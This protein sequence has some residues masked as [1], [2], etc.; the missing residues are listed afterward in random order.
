MAFKDRNHLLKRKIE[1]GVA[2][3]FARAYQTVTVQPE[4][5]LKQLQQAHGLPIHGFHDLYSLPQEVLDGIADETIAAAKKMAAIEGAG[6]GIFGFFTVAPDMAI[7]ASISLQMM[8]KLSLIYGFEYSTDEEKAELWLATASAFGLDISK[9]LLEKHV[10]ER[11]AGKMIARISAKLGA[12]VAEKIVAKVV[13]VLGSIAGGAL[14][15]YFVRL[16]G[17]RIKQHFREKHLA[18]RAQQS[19]QLG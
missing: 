15:H 18:V 10:I 6:L 19:L 17:R 5:Y 16:W 1:A 8:Q 3:G 4:A 14:N 2:R 9:E 11:F 7:L 12:E 13:P